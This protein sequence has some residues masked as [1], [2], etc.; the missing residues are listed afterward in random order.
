MKVLYLG[1][2]TL[3][4][5]SQPIE[6]IDDALHELIRNMFITME[7]D[8]G[9]GLAAP[10]I[11]KNI[12]LF[13]VKIDDGVERVFINPLII[14]TSEK[15]CSFEEGCLSIPQIY[16][17]VTRPESVTVQYQDINGRRKKIEASGLLAR[18]IQHEY[19][20]LEGILFIDRLA[21][22]ER[23]A[24]VDRFIQK[25]ERAKQRAAKKRVHIS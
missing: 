5:P 18:V 22:N 6:H 20:H 9:I 21:E 3:R 14:G 15:Q 2:Q 12:R 8:R 13:V 23:E 19:D 10:Q 25:Q 4:Q 11:G 24:L 1:E 16:A 7:E 17:D